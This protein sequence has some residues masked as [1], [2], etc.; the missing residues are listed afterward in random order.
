MIGCRNDPDNACNATEQFE[1]VLA[2]IQARHDGE[3]GAPRS[4]DTS[5]I[6]A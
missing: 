1:N 2:A 5:G 4:I 3:I 6:A